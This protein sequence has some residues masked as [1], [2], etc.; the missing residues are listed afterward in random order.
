MKEYR[1][2]RFSI[3]PGATEILLVRHGESRAAVPGRPFPLVDNQGDPALSELG[4]AQALRVAERFGTHA[5]DAIYATSL[6]RTVET[7]TPLAERSGIKIRVEPA[8]RE[9]HLGKW[10]G[11]LF[12]IKVHENDPIYQQVQAQQRWDLIPGA[13]SCEQLRCRVG[14]ALKQIIAHHQNQLVIAVLHGGVIGH[15]L[16]EATRSEAFAFNGCD[17]ASV[18]HIVAVEDK[19]I[20]RG[21][22]DVTHLAGLEATAMPT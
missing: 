7:A 13:E 18:S 14:M 2:H 10:E 6:Q 5:I 1:Q 21:F 3:P 16:A 19:I 20:L 11:G 9:V 12:R 15:I 8:L 17:N 22:N 4:R